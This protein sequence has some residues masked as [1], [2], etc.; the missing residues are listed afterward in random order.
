MCALA[1]LEVVVAKGG[2]LVK[3][4]DF[5]AAFFKDKKKIIF[6]VLWHFS[7]RNLSALSSNCLATAMC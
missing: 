7:T 5:E 4:A 3:E 1:V 2:C 6:Y